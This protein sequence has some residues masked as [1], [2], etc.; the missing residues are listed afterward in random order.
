MRVISE[1]SQDTTP[2]LGGDLDLNSS[3]IT[4]TG[5]INITGTLQTSSN[6]II[7]GDLTVSGSTTTVNT[8]EINLADNNITLNSNHTGT[9][10]QNAGL[11]VERGTSADKVF[12][13]NESSDYWEVDD[14]FNVAGNITVTGTVDGRDVATDGTKLDG[15]ETN[16]T[17]DQ[18]ASEIR[19]LVE[20][21]TDS[22]V[23]TDADHTKLNNIEASADVTD[24]TNVTAAGAL[25][26]SEVTNLA[27]VKA[28]DSSDY[29]TAAQGT[30]ADAA[31]PKTG[32]A[33]TGAITTN[34]TFD[35]RDVATDGTKLDGIEASADVTDTTNV[36]AA[37][38]LMDSEVTNLSQVKAFDSSDYATAAQGTTAD[39]ALPKAGGTMTGDITFNSGQTFDGRDVSVDG[40]RLDDNIIYNATN[41]NNVAGVWEATISDVTSYTDGLMIAFYPNKINGVSGGTTFEINSLGAKTV[42]RPDGNTTAITTHYNGT[43]LIFLRYVSADDYFI[44][45]ANYN[46]T[47]DYRIRYEHH[48]T[49]NNS[50]GSGTAWFGYE[51]LME[52]IDGKFYP[53]TEG[54]S[55]GNTN[56]VSTAELRVGGVMLIY[57]DST[58]RTANTN[59]G[60]Y[61]LY[62]AVRLTTME[63]WNNRDSGWAT[64]YRPWYIVAT[65]NANGNFVLDNTSFT[66]FLTQDLPTSDDGKYY[67][68]GGLMLDTYDDYRLQVNHPVYVYKNGAVREWGGYADNA[69]LL[70]NLE[71]TSF[72]RSDADDTATGQLTLTSSSTY[73][74]IINGSDNGK[75]VLKGSTSPYIRFQE[76][77]ADKAYIQWNGNTDSLHIANQQDSSLLRIKDAIEFST[78]GTNFNSVWHGGN[79]GT[80]SGLDADLLDGNEATVF[81]KIKHTEFDLTP[82]TTTVDINTSLDNSVYKYVFVIADVNTSSGPYLPTLSVKRL[83][84]AASWVGT[85][86]YTNGSDGSIPTN[87]DLWSGLTYYSVPTD[88]IIIEIYRT[89]DRWIVDVSQGHGTAGFHFVRG[90]ASNI[91]RDYISSITLGTGNSY[92][93]TKVQ[94][95][96][97]EYS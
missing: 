39:A 1:V 16:A 57:S 65:I 53:V 67:I 14:A 36:T 37:G 88:G 78:D 49:A 25:M 64:A 55:T 90:Y 44:V 92:T 41:T 30:T 40:T 5:N 47:D 42:T 51:L 20:S 59:T 23:F 72:V 24:A 58:N 79:D 66:S 94:G 95:H 21:A 62:E 6:A 28:F 27:Q 46:T 75:I 19:T 77:T 48:V 63:H 15:I 71:A 32:G 81:A 4:G 50:A 34:S 69:N 3:D 93:W 60:S 73:P 52:G 80:G 35:G 68:H 26:D 13:W 8:E 12:Q 9:P 96:L 61:R 83:S 29:A 82:G 84:T 45:H 86:A 31:L 74:L 7:G 18:T 17:S 54:G 85:Y 89:T 43:N 33:M 87:T 22:N 56:A 76:S 38:A 70:D 91:T 11:T 2:Q 10:T 97:L